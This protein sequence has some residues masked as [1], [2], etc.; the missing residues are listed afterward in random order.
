MSA[1]TRLRRLDEHARITVIEGGPA[2]SL[3]TCGMPYVIGG[4]IASRDALL[5]QKPAALKARF[6]LDVRVA[7]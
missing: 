5:L 2:V 6:D 7:R 3:A 4:D 1:A